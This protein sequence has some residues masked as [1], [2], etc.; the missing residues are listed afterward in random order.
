MIDD[1]GLTLQGKVV[2]SVAGFA[3]LGALTIGVPLLANVGL[4]VAAVASCGLVA[5]LTQW[6]VHRQHRVDWSTR[7]QRP[8][9]RR[10][11]DSRVDA[12]CAQIERAA[13]GEPRPV[14]ELHALLG[15]LADDRLHQARGISR[16][17]HPHDAERLLG[18]DLTAYLAHPPAGRLGAA[19][20]SGFVTTLEELS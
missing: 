11:A 13:N 6:L 19:R 14:A 15:S 16:S 20:L 17:S 9:D 8:D 7:F 1:D 4:L 2:A 18:P 3:L 10:G 5:V 12:T